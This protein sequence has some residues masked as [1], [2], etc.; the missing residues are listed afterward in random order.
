MLP[1]V[2]NL[3]AAL[4]IT[5]MYFYLKLLDKKGYIGFWASGWVVYTASLA[6]TFAALAGYQS[7]ALV[8]S[9]Q[10]SALIS[11]LLFLWGIFA[12]TGKQRTAWY[13]YISVLAAVIIVIAGNF[14]PQIVYSKY[15]M[16]SLCVIIY[17]VTGAAFILIA[18]NERIGNIITGLAFILWGVERAVFTFLRADLFITPWG[19]LSVLTL[20]IIVS[21]ALLVAYF[22]KEINILGKS[23]ERFRHLTENARDII[24]RYRLTPSQDMIM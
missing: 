12:F 3:I 14:T 20:S 6:M 5:L 1:V 9:S 13:F 18:G 22:Q 21:F 16:F 15:F 4:I 17:V 8:I 24:Y 2:I 23:G 19:Y 10:L 11:G 7:L